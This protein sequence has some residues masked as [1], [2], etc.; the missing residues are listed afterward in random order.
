MR[1]IS[2]FSGIEA[3]SVAWMPL[4][5]EPVALSE[6]DPF[7]CAVLAERM[8]SVPN[9][10]DMTKVD[11]SEYH[12]AADLVIGGSPCQSF[13]V[14][15]LRKGLA[16]PRGNLM[17]EYLRACSEIDPEWIIWENVPGV[18][19]AD[20]RRAFQTFLEAVVELWPRG[21][22]CWRIIDAQFCGVP[23]RR[24]RVFVVINTRD[25]RRSAAVLLEPDCL[26]GNNPSSRKKRE[27]LAAR[28]GRGA[29]GG[30]CFG[31][32]YKSSPGAGSIGYDREIA[33]SLLAARNDAAC[34]QRTCTQFGE[35]IAGTLT[36][37][38][39]SSP[40]ADRGMNV[41]CMQETVS[42]F[43]S[44]VD[45]TPP[46]KASQAGSPQIICLSDTQA[47]TAAE[48]DMC[49]TL[50]AHSA[51]DAPV[52]ASNG[53]GFVGA[54]CARDFKGVGSQFV[55]EGKV[56]AV[57]SESHYIVRRLTPLECERLQGFPDSWT[58]V[59]YKGK[60]ADECPDAPRYKALGNSMA[61]PVIRWIG[62]RIEMVEDLI[63][64][65]ML[66]GAYR[67]LRREKC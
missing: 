65:L 33:P 63:V 31:F 10:G 53:E 45:H 44:C 27:E 6:I 60:I 59:P 64:D 42:D 5:W 66:E 38:A 28:A 16:D 51:K 36:A 23:Q 8:P 41:I 43:V 47:N 54:L 56:L 62:E 46:I 58:R 19:S 12:G 17:L 48:D 15:G 26:Q 50:S 1:Y 2:L 13:S 32:S 25:W 9:L 21:G 49:G 40:C 61:V 22:V 18:L 35:E 37:R 4:G 20:G 39:D 30:G 52:I 57:K 3:A 14:A 67:P 34:V 29:A 55:H 7:P 24:R 11:W